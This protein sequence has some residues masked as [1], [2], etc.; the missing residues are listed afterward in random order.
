MLSG[1]M[2]KGGADPVNVPLFSP[3]TASVQWGKDPSGNRWQPG[4]GLPC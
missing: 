3:L 2:A 4:G 1:D